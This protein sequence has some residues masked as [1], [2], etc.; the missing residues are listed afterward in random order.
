M[1][2]WIYTRRGGARTVEEPKSF[3]PAR[4]FDPQS[5]NHTVPEQTRSKKFTA[6][7]GRTECPRETT[8]LLRPPR[9]DMAGTASPESNGFTT[10]APSSW[11]GDG[12]LGEGGYQDRCPERVNGWR[13]GAAWAGGQ[14]SHPLPERRALSR[15]KNMPETMTLDPP[16]REVDPH[17]EEEI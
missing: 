16:P 4:Y 6:R 14:N 5:P 3:G 11:L 1:K 15:C 12:G 8:I 7:R 13:G 2:D 9:P 10:T 17:P